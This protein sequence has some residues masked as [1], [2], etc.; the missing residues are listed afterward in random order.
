MNSRQSQV[1]L[2]PLINEK[3][4]QM[5]ILGQYTFEVARD[6]NKIEIA[7]AMKQLIKELY[8]QK[9]SDVVKVNTSAI[10]GRIRRSKRHGAAPRDSKKAIITISGDQLDIFSA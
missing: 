7:Q 1:I 2:R 8:P 5:A 6:A 3:S 4:A 10:R 9:K